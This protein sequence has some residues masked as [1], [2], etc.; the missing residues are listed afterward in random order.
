MY[1][2]TLGFPN[3]F[4]ACLDTNFFTQILSYMGFLGSLILVCIHLLQTHFAWL[5]VKYIYVTQL[6]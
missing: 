1:S 4:V 6:Y 3:K 5:K 2:H